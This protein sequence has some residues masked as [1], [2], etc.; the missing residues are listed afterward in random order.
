MENP[1]SLLQR[2]D[3]FRRKANCVK[4]RFCLF[5]VLKVPIVAAGTVVPE[6]RAD[7]RRGGQAESKSGST[8]LVF[9][10]PDGRSGVLDHSRFISQ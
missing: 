10:E 3:I 5:S 6:E 4:M 1:A 8:E 9:A 7:C 2:Y